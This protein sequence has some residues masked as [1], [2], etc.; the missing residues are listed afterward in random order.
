LRGN[1]SLL[2]DGFVR[3]WRSRRRHR[4]LDLLTKPAPGEE[5]Q[6]RPQDGETSA[7]R[8]VLEEIEDTIDEARR[9]GRR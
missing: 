4:A 3:R 6:G 7:S 9:A 1:D 8:S 5:I 2:E